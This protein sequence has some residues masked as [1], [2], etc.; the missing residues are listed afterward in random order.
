M[1]WAQVEKARDIM[2]CWAANGYRLMLHL[3]PPCSTF[4]RARDR[5][6]RTRLRSSDHPEGLAHRAAECRAANTIALRALA[7][8]EWAASELGAA[9]SMEN[10][11]TSYLWSFLE[12]DIGVPFIDAQFS[13]CMYGPPYRKNTTL[14]CWGWQPSSLTKSC[15]LKQGAFTCG[16]TAAQG[17]KVLEFGGL[18]TSD[19]AA[20]H[21]GGV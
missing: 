6:A 14:R 12:P 2:A 20:Y 3:A 7:L 10:P 17:H 8:A 18:R 19:A 16:R 11:Q 13:A 21:I 4:S 9:V 15:S 5:S 1:D